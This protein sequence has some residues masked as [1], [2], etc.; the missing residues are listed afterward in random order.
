MKIVI[1]TGMK[2]RCLL[3]GHVFVMY[4]QMKGTF[5]ILSNQNV[6]NISLPVGQNSLACLDIKALAHYV[7][8]PIQYTGC[9]I[10]CF[11]WTIFLYF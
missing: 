4:V 11:Q 9:N 7:N 1:F 3:H 8:T 6:L 10:G 5:V 2:N